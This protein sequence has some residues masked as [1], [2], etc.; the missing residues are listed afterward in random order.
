M[1]WGGMFTFFSRSGARSADVATFWIMGSVCQK[2]GV[3]LGLFSIPGE[4]GNW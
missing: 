1:G 3:W 2:L 4:G